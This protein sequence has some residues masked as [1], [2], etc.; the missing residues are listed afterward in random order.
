MIQLQ[1]Q[2]PLPRTCISVSAGFI[3][4]LMNEFSIVPYKGDSHFE[5][6]PSLAEKAFCLK[7]PSGERIFYYDVEPSPCESSTRHVFVLIH[8]LGDEADSFRHLIPLLAAQ[9]FRLLALDLPGFGR[10]VTQGKISLKNHAAAVIKLIESLI[11]PQEGPAE[12]FLAGNSMGALVAEIAAFQRPDLVSGLILIDGSIP[13]GPTNPGPLAIAKMLFSRK[14]YKAYRD[15][16][17]ALWRSLFPF[18]ADL[19]SLPS[20]DKEFLKKR[21]KARVES[22]TQE[23]AFF[24]SQSDLI[25]TYLFSSRGITRKIQ[26]YPGKILL[27][28]GENDN[29]IPISSTKVFTALR[30]DIKLE[31][32]LGAG[33][34]P[35][36][37]KPEDLARLMKGFI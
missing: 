24:A 19:G 6:W 25:M 2:G 8:G 5:P 17:D 15:A 18:Y 13:G 35:Q 4:I 14:W 16:P 7:Y 27:I 3:I 1:R 29:I 22:S 26:Y 12:I 21:I 28:W 9:G 36:Q 23:R 30:N 10:S 31:V 33:H 37:D 11:Q 34:L 32:I 20:A